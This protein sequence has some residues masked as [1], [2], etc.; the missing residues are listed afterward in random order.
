[1]PEMLAAQ[2]LNLAKITCRKRWGWQILRTNF[3]IKHLLCIGSRKPF[4]PEMLAAQLP[5][6]A[7]ITCR[8]RCGGQ[9]IKT[10]FAIKHLLYAL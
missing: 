1:M 3:A 6:P 9:I 8:K 4:I 10:S 5:N 2:L 7:K